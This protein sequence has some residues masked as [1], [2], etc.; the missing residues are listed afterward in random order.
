MTS[1]S[2]WCRF[3]VTLL[4]L[5]TVQAEA[6]MPAD[7]PLPSAPTPQVSI[8]TPNYLAM[9]TSRDPFKAYAPSQVPEPNLANSSRLDQLIRDGK[10]YL[11]LQDAIALALENNLDL[12]IARYNIPIADTDILRTKAGA[13]FRG[14][15]TGIVGGTPGGGV[16]GFGAGA[17]GAGAGGTTAGSG[18]AGAGAAGL[19]QSTLGTGTAVQS[20]DPVISGNMGTEHQTTP[21]SNLQIYGVPA[22]QLNNWLVNLNYS[23]AFPTGTSVSFEVDNNRTATN[24][25]YSSLSPQLGTFYR[26]QLQQ[27][28]L[29]GFGFGPNLRFLRIARNNKKISDIAFKSQVIAT[30]TQ[31]ANIYWDLVSAYEEERVNEQSFAFAQQSLENARKQLQLQAIPA[32]DVMRAEAEVSRR[33]QDLTVARTNLQLQESLIKNALTRNLDDPVLESMPVVPTDKAIISDTGPDE[34]VQELITRALQ[35]RPELSESDIDLQNRLISRKAANN[36]LLPT[37]ERSCVLRRQWSGGR[38]ESFL[39]HDQSHHRANRFLG[40]HSR[41]RSTAP[42]PIT[43]WD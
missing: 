17:P 42:P 23:Q 36:A 32:M 14:V 15:N 18:G 13:S 19:V 20:F 29:A 25:I 27:Q 2:P 39:L 8:K 35:D 3:L 28:L 6:Q 4:C 7:A 9:P 5:L 33:D 16:G 34:S 22:L 37:S 31:I 21:L 12:A 43:L 38:A 40:S 24:S 10:L 11:S 30:V 1:P 41:M 26:V